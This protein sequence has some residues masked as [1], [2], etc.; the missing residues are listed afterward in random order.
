ML[1]HLKHVKFISKHVKFISKHVKFIS[2][3]V[4]FSSKHVKLFRTRFNMLKHFK[5]ILKQVS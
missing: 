3:H 4:K 2:K 5:I 1:K